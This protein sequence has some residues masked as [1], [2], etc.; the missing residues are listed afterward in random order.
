MLAGIGDQRKLE[1]LVEAGFSSVDAIQITT[2]NGARFL[3][4]DTEI[5]SISV[6]ERAALVLLNGDVVKDISAIEKPD[7]VLKAGV[8]D[9]G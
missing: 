6:G 9:D 8:G 3:G 2:L 4:L 1:L 5:G 7:L